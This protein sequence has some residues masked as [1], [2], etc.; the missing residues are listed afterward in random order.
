MKT[1]ADTEIEHKQKYIDL[2]SL[3]VRTMHNIAS[4]PN[5]EIYLTSCSGYAD[6]ETAGKRRNSR[7]SGFVEDD[8]NINACREA[9]GLVDAV[10]CYNLQVFENLPIAT[11]AYHLGSS[12]ENSYYK[13]TGYDYKK[14]IFTF[15]AGLL[16]SKFKIKHAIF[17][18]KHRTVLSYFEKNN[19][20]NF[21]SYDEQFLAELFL[22]F[23]YNSSHDSSHKDKISYLFG[24]LPI[25]S[26]YQTDISE[27]YHIKIRTKLLQELTNRAI[28][29]TGQ[30]LIDG[31]ITDNINENEMYKEDPFLLDMVEYLSTELHKNDNYG[32]IPICNNLSRLYIMYSDAFFNHIQSIKIENPDK[33]IVYPSVLEILNFT[34]HDTLLINDTPSHFDRKLLNFFVHISENARSK[35][36]KIGGSK[37]TDKYFSKYLKYKLKY[38]NIKNKSF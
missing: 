30:S 36:P 33:F 11:F 34:T 20:N 23:S 16:A 12:P 31:T 24:I 29:I 4:Q 25:N 2:Y 21:Q 26:R 22:I 5:C 9:D 6:V 27:K 10:D 32:V 35:F 1:K 17:D 3:Y 8:V 37:N 14:F 28:S 7:F 13:K 38:L 18:Q 15:S 19:L